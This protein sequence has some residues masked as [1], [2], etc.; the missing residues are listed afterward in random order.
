[1]KAEQGHIYAQILHGKCHYVFTAEQMPE[2]NEEH[3]QVVDVTD[4]EERPVE[5]MLYVDGQFLPE[6]P[7]ITQEK[8]NEEARAYLRNTDWYIIRELDSGELCPEDIKAGRAA[9]RA[10]IIG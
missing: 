8:I 5:R 6:P 3:I 1:M 2:W 9:A 7:T 10:R 4:L